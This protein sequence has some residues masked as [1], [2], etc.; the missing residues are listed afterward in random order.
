M[1]NAGDPSTLTTHL[2]KKAAVWKHFRFRK[3]DYEGTADK[4]IAICVICHADVKYCSNTTNLRNHLTRHHP[5]VLV[6]TPPPTNRQPNI[7]NA[8]TSKIPHNSPRAQKITES[9]AIFICKDI[10]PYSVVENDGFRYMLNVL[11]PRYS[12]PSRKQISEE[13]IP[14]LYNEVKRNI[15]VSLQSA[16][17][18]ALT[19]G[20]TSRSQDS[21]V[22]ITCHYL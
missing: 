12:V 4:N 3:H 22:T 10:R 7:L 11:E 5:E 19:C 1:A 16:D 2:N 6:S 20:W 14:R 9:I 17:R 13:V 18:V 15:A 21:Y 8:L